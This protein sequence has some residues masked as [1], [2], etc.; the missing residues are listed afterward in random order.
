MAGTT[1]PTAGS[2]RRGAVLTV[3]LVAQVAVAG[4]TFTMGLGWG[5]W[6]YLLAAVQSLLGVGVVVWLA[7]RRGGWWPLAV[8]VASAILT[9]TLALIG[10]GVAGATACTDPERAAF[11]RL[12]APY[13]TRPA[14]AGESTGL[15]VARFTTRASAEDIEAHYERDFATL[16]WE[17]RAADAGERTSAVT[18]EGVA[19]VVLVEEGG[20]IGP[21]STLVV[22]EVTDRP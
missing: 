22:V 18:P 15:C 4:F 10:A 3:G 8:P 13:G 7:A 19:V 20:T 12:T 14:L 6:T 5:S 9:A 11:A 21:D 1:P 16:G 17:S 2:P